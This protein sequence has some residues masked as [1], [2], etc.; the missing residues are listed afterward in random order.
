MYQVTACACEFEGAAF[1]WIDTTWRCADCINL[2]QCSFITLIYHLRLSPGLSL[3][4]N[5]LTFWRR[6]VV[7]CFSTAKTARLACINKQGVVEGVVTLTDLFKY[8]AGC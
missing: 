7:A 4:G 6:Q 5:V 3:A 1:A 8:L 2:V